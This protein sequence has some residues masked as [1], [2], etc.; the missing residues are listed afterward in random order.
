M[1]ALNVIDR[2]HGRDGRDL[3][4]VGFYAAFRH[5]KAEEFSPRNPENSFFGV[6]LHP[7]LLKF[8]EDLLEVGD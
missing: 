8:A 2:P 4:R 7:K 6:K 5:D 3:L 1:Q